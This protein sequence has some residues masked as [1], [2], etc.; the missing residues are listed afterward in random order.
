MKKLKL[1]SNA[2]IF[3]AQRFIMTFMM[4]ITLLSTQAQTEN[5]P[6]RWHFEIDLRYQQELCQHNWGKG[7]TPDLDFVD[8][9]FV[10]KGIYDYE[11]TYTESIFDKFEY[12]GNTIMLYELYD[13]NKHMSIGAGLGVTHSFKQEMWQLPL[14]GTLRYKPW[15]TQPYTYL[16]TD[17]GW[18]L[19]NAESPSGDGISGPMFNLGIGK[20]FSIGK[21]NRLD[22]KIGYHLLHYKYEYRYDDI[23]YFFFEQD[24]L[25]QHNVNSSE[26]YQQ[27]STTLHNLQLSVGFVF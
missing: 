17:L 9:H 6:R 5:K 3:L 1:T 27:L 11:G 19:T 22:L 4:F 26:L 12:G 13:L 25:S 18:T 15:S 14:F 24:A 7:R 10:F 23:G 20:S 2:S 8:D 16:Y 21:K